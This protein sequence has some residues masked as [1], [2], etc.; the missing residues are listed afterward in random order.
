MSKE[1][2]QDQPANEDDLKKREEALAASEAK[3]K[4]DQDILKKDQ[5]QLKDDQEK[6][7]TD[8]NDLDKREKALAKS[9][10]ETKPAKELPGVEFEF[11]GLKK[12]FTDA[13]PKKIRY[14]GKVWSQDE[15]IED[16]DALMDLVSSNSHYFENVNS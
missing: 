1:N 13:A 9:Q 14:D 5:D 11:Q 10:K 2:T 4:A 3:L 8:R 6:L 12:K 15:L 7:V 16:E